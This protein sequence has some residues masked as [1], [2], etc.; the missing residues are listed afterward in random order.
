MKRTILA[1]AVGGAALGLIGAGVGASFT[2]GSSATE[3][4]HVGTLQVVI[5]SVKAP[6][7]PPGCSAVISTDGS[8]LTVTCPTLNSS[9]AGTASFSFELK[10]TGTMDASS[11]AIVV[12]NPGVA[13][14]SATPA[15]PSFPLA[16]GALHSVGAGLTWTTLDNN[17][18]GANVS[19]TY[20]ITANA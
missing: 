2:S 1:L 14:F 9:A 12:S 11:V 4:I 16:V 7:L 20:T 10:N 13:N 17:D 8:S 18:M 15:P 6:S 19:V 3:N 5:N